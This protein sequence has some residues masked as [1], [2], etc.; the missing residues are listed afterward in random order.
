[1]RAAK[2][3]LAVGSLIWLAGCATP[4]PAPV[5]AISPPAPAEPAPPP[6][7]YTADAAVLRQMLLR[8]VPQAVISGPAE[9]AAWVAR[10]KAQLAASPYRLTAPQLLVAV[11]RNPAV[12]QMRI[13]L[14]VPGGQWE[15]IGGDKVSTGR[16]G[17]KGYYVTPTGVFAH[18]DAILD[19]RAE[20][21]YNENHIRGLGIKGRRVWDFG[22]RTAQKG[23]PGNGETGEI[24]LL[25]HATDPDVL[26]PRLGRPDSMGCV[27]ISARM[28]MFL[29][30]HA[31]LDKDYLQ[32]A[33]TDPRFAAIL[34]PGGTPSPFAGTYLV[35]FDS[36]R[37][38]P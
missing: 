12:Q 17:R 28:N 18:D 23:W 36:A 2:I 3:A 11:D 22:W 30:R 15:V 27:R 8:E 6:H 29:D 24:R 35:I 16:R 33:R 37:P 32:A 9:N 31:V 19:Y 4:R 1:M 13:I 14:A 38:G 26:E 7:D 10:T 20:G 5:A 25:M 21:T 34:A